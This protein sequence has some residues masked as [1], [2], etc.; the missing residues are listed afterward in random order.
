MWESGTKSNTE[1]DPLLQHCALSALLDSSERMNPARCHP[2]T[3]EAVIEE[4]MAWIG[5][6]NP[7]PS[8]MVMHGPVGSGKSALAQS[9][10]ER[11]KLQY[12][13]AAAF[14]FSRTAPGRNNG[15]SLF[16]TIVYQL[17]STYPE[18]RPAIWMRLW[19][20]PSLLKK[21]I[22]IVAAEL[23]IAPFF[24][25]I[26]IVLCWITGSF[27][28]SWA[29]GWVHPRLIVIDGLDECDNTE[30]QSHILR[31]AAT[32]TRRLRRPFRILITCRPEIHIMQTL[33]D[34]TFNY[35]ELDLGKRN[36][37]HDIELFLNDKF[38]ELKNNHPLTKH[39]SFPTSWPGPDIIAKITENASGQFIYASAIM[40]Y[41]KSIKSSPVD[42]LNII[43]GSFDKPDSDK[44]FAPLD[45]LYMHIFSSVEDDSLLRQILGFM[46]IP[47]TEDDNLGQYTTPA[48]IATLLSLMSTDSVFL[49]L[50]Q[51]RSVINS[52][53]PNSPIKFWHASISDFLLDKER[54]KDFFVDIQWVHEILARGYLRLFQSQPLDLFFNSDPDFF[55]FFLEHYKRATLSERLLQDL[56]SYDFFSAYKAAV[57]PISLVKMEQA[58]ESDMV[59]QLFQTLV[60]PECSKTVLRLEIDLI[61]GQV[62]HPQGQNIVDSYIDGLYRNYPLEDWIKESLELF[63]DLKKHE[64]I[65]WLICLMCSLRT[66]VTAV[67]IDRKQ[68]SIMLFMSPSY[69]PCCTATLQPVGLTSGRNL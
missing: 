67:T 29:F 54:S 68:L 34:S 45:A 56:I 15:L 28:F 22:E 5:D 23:L 27:F 24:S 55:L 12:W 57:K 37:S 11:C 41:I 53:D 44:P 2:K 46:A 31:A 32:A 66:D 58:W 36:A 42:R 10:A 3:R 52:A 48:M 20:E 21:S 14:F 60:R 40:A 18:V 69:M 35:S 51:L 50:D 30:I 25:W 38:K 7:A 63:L 64:N 17:L 43:L 16:P 33:N 47:R 65:V 4:I 62:L 9:I 19:R 26:Y 13:L 6:S 61:F 39:G 59:L 8:M 1:S 49:V